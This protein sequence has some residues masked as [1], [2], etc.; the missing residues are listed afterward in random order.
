MDYSMPGHLQT[1]G[2][3]GKNC[4]LVCPLLVVDICIH[5]MYIPHHRRC[6][7]KYSQ[8][9]NLYVGSGNT[10]LILL[11]YLDHS[12]RIHNYYTQVY[13]KDI[14]QNSIVKAV[15]IH[16]KLWTQLTQLKFHD[17]LILL[18]HMIY[19]WNLYH[20]ENLDCLSTYPIFN[21]FLESC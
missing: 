20:S 19:S 7:D 21:Y 15:N 8:K 12:E 2:H 14:L 10:G 18:I 6:L 4:I 5:N 13:K 17:I 9:Y 3:T 11:N 16:Y 1:D